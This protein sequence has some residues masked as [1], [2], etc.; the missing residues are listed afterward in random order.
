[1]STGCIGLTANLAGLFIHNGPPV[2]YEGL[3]DQRVAIVCMMDEGE[4]NSKAVQ[5]L[6]SYIH[7]NINS[8]V[9]DVDTVPQTTVERWLERH[10]N[11]EFDFVDIG[12]GVRAEKV[13]A[14]DIANLTLMNGQTLYQGKA[15]ITVT[16]HD[17][18]SQKLEFR[19]DLPEF[20]YPNM[21]GPAVT[22]VTESKFR[23]LY[24]QIMADRISSLFYPVDMNESFALDAKSNSL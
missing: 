19:K 3:E 7:A 22:D 6:T 20:T 21:G 12:K 13:V 14:I 4:M 18:E 9:D 11:G 10:P 23:G 2:E 17:V 8:H 15:D 5:M 16:V 1:M 24:L